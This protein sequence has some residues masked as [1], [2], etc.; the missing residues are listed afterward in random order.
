MGRIIR[1]SE[2]WLADHTVGGVCAYPSKY[3]KDAYDRRLGDWV[4]KQQRKFT[5]TLQP[6]L[7]VAEK[8]SL[9]ALPGW[10]FAKYR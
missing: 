3:A 8:N 6:I 7:G 10:Q 4:S 1:E 5:G 2:T 9:E